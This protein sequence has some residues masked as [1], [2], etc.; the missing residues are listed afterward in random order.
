[1]YRVIEGG[2]KGR[3]VVGVVTIKGRVG[4]G[5]VIKNRRVGGG[6]ILVLVQDF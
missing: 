4:G 5:V 3:R 2:I 6:R 1:M